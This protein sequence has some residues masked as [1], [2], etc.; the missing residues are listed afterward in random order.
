MQLG[1]VSAILPNW[2]FEQLLTFAAREGYDC[3][4]VM[5]WPP[6]G[7]S[8]GR[9]ERRYAGVCHIDVTNF[10]QARAD[11][12][13]ALCVRH[14]V[15]ISGLGYYPNMLSGDR[16][17]AGVAIEHFKKVVLA[18]A[19]LGLR[20]V[21]TFIGADHRLP[22]NENFDRFLQV[23]PDLVR[24]VQDYGLFLGIENCPMLFSRDQWPSGKNLAH[25]PAVWRRMFEAIPSPH[26]GLNYDPS[27][28]VLQMMD[29]L[30][31]LYEF[32]ERLFHLHAK[33]MKIE[34][35]RLDDEGILSIGQTKPGWSTPKVPGLG[36][37]DWNRFVS[38]LTDV[39]YR[40]AICVEVEDRAFEHDDESRQRSLKV[41][42]NTL[43]PL[44]G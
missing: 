22:L 21:N 9:A 4:E 44:I 30:A 1:F 6:A 15:H 35:Q 34:R 2:S 7:D 33:D 29:Y 41:S 38:V 19:L 27:H 12:I 3:V 23:W 8:G 42:R 36:D 20:N 11:E 31:P 39:G 37:I 14:G 43:R 25:S 17:E 26:F 13:N 18:A 40:G 10:S 28:M 24:L 32:R 16:E 5:C